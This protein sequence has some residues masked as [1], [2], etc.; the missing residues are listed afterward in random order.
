MKKLFII[1]LAIVACGQPKKGSVTIKGPVDSFRTQMTEKVE[2]YRDRDLWDSAT[3][4]INDLEDTVV[5]LNN[6]KL[7]LYWR[8]EKAQQL[9]GDY[10]FDSASLFMN[11]ALS[12]LGNTN[13]NYKDSFNSYSVYVHLL[14]EQKLYDSALRIGNQAYYLAK[15]DSPRIVKACVQLAQIYASV[16]DLSNVRKY[17]LKA[18]EYRDKAPD[19]ISSIAKLIMHYYYEKDQ[20]DS[21]M[22]YLKIYQSLPTT[23][24]GDVASAY[25]NNGVFYLKQGKL[26]DA[27]QNYLKAKTI[28]DSMGIKGS[29]LLN[30]LADAYKTIGQYPKALQYIDSSIVS[31]QE[32]K[33]FYNL[34]LA[35]QTKSE[36][37]F[38]TK[39]YKEAYSA[40]DSSYSYYSQE[41]DSSL[42]KTARELETKYAVQEKDNQIN[43]LALTN[44]ANQR[45][46]NQQRITIIIMIIAIIF[47]AIIGVLLWRRRQEQMLRRENNLKQQILRAQME[48]HFIFNALSVLQNLIR[49]G[50]TEKAIG[51]LNNL[52]KLMRF[53]FENASKTFILLESEIEALEAYLNLQMVYH[54]GLFTY[55]L[56]VYNDYEEE[57]IYIPPMLLQPVVENSIQHGFSQINYKGIIEIKIERRSNTIHC[58][59]QD[60]G[61][62]F[63]SVRE[64]K[65]LHSIEINKER[66]SILAKQTGEPASFQV[67]DKK[68]AMG[69]QG[70][71]TEIEIPIKINKADAVFG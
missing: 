38:N 15:N 17:A 21:L 52:A 20:G 41:T 2:D 48:P 30:N 70:V 55:D 62:G 27:I 18:W 58:I 46:R 66:L 37:L 61:K 4:Y 71:R 64:N 19:W 26:E 54:P 12:L 45:V 35:W 53:N 42:R 36:I 47:L 56:K 7:T 22:Y 34:S 1:S 49:A 3:H 10:R 69:Q 33:N 31:A 65:K 59:I 43:T 6:D 29:M 63:Q 28:L 24:P 23:L 44:V 8:L 51:Y 25:E 40:L 67:T 39:Q 14:T 60:N 68:E 9:L 50:V 32:D 11:K 5:K 16:N 57:E 13:F